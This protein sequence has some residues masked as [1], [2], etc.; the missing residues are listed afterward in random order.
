MFITKSEYDELVAMTRETESYTNE[1]E[2][3][4]KDNLELL[5]N[6]Q[7]LEQKLK[8]VNELLELLSQKLSQANAQLKHLNLIKESMELRH[9]VNKSL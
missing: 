2:R 4:K 1:N 5:A 3:L 6:V 8:C 9:G 7:T